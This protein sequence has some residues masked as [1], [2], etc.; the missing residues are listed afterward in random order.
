[1]AFFWW[2]KIGNK[3]LCFCM[4]GYFY[5]FFNNINTYVVIY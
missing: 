4:I 1:M 2:A 3:C 5:Y